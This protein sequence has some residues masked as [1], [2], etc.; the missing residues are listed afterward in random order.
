MASLL[1][2]RLTRR[3]AGLV[4]AGNGDACDPGR[5]GAQ[6]GMARIH[7][8]DRIEIVRVDQLDQLAEPRANHHDI[9]CGKLGADV[10]DP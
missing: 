8:G 9:G 2:D 10:N 5:T 6:T 7:D 4:E 3:S 1:A